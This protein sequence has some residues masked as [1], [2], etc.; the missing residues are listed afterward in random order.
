MNYCQF[1]S[2]PAEAMEGTEAAVCSSCWDLLKEPSTALPLIR[3]HLTLTLRG[4]MPEEELK[5]RIDAF[6]QMI[7]GWK[8]PG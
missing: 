7:A 1:C 2:K 3:G 6:M 5:R 8:R 4:T